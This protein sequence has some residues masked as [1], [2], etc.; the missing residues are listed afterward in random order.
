MRIGTTVQPGGKAWFAKVANGGELKLRVRDNKHTDN[1]GSYQVTI[2]VI[3]VDLLLS[4][5]QKLDALG[6][7]TPCLE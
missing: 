4:D 7:A 6:V 2:V 5:C 3:P 1:T